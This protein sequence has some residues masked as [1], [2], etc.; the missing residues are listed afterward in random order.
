VFNPV[1]QLAKRKSVRPVDE[2]LVI[3]VALYGLVQRLGDR[4]RLPITPPAVCIFVVRH[5]CIY[6]ESGRA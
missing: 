3:P 1:R 6:Y 4:P 5:K 2:G